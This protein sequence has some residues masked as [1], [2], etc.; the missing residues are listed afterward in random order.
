LVLRETSDT[1]ISGRRTWAGADSTPNHRRP[2]QSAQAS[3]AIRAFE[4]RLP[5]EQ[6]IVDD[7]YA[8]HF[9]G[10]VWRVLVNRFSTLVRRALHGAQ[11]FGAARNRY[12]DDLVVSAI[13]TGTTQV[14][15]IC[16]GYETTAYRLAR[17]GVRFFEVDIPPTLARKRQLLARAGIPTPAGHIE[18]PMDLEHEDLAARLVAAGFDPSRAALVVWSGGTYYVPRPGVVDTLRKLRALLAPGSRVSF[19]YPLSG[20][21]TGEIHYPGINRV[22]LLFRLYG[23]PWRFGATADDIRDIA[24]ELRYDPPVIAATNELRAFLP[25]VRATRPLMNYAEI[26]TLIVPLGPG[27][28]A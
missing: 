17:P 4:L 7:P 26:A 20:V 18:V 28:H 1:S 16:P 9:L 11:E 8:P 6:R 27:G 19:D 21:L 3:A 10:T 13:S 22:L 12:F 15:H 25:A 5:P 24:R 23:E 2:S 14:V